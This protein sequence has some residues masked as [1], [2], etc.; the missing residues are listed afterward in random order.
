MQI[1]IANCYEQVIMNDAQFQT[2]MDEIKK[3]Q[4]EVEGKL[5]SSIAE[6][7]K[8]GGELGAGKDFAGAC[9]KK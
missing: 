2:L 8:A 9:T 1:G 4:C 5:T 7:I 3:S 6:L